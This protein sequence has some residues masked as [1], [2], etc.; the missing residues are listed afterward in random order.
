MRKAW[1]CQERMQQQKKKTQR[2]KG[3]H[4][5]YLMAPPMSSISSVVSS[6]FTL[7]CA[8]LPS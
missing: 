8:S 4:S 1:P 2:K 6:T 5:L 7:S 3:L